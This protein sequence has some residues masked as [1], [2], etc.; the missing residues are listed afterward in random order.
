MGSVSWHRRL[1][2]I[3]LSIQ[4][5]FRKSKDSHLFREFLFSFASKNLREAFWVWVRSSW[6]ESPPTPVWQSGGKSNNNIPDGFFW[7]HGLNFL[8][9]WYKRHIQTSTLFSDCYNQDCNQGALQKGIACSSR[10]ADNNHIAHGF[11]GLAKGPQ[12]QWWE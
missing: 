1:G 4:G 8:R 9:H 2:S 5:L 12:W 10:P 6:I 7:V 3:S 11:Q